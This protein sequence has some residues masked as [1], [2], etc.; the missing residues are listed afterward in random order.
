MSTGAWDEEEGEEKK[1]IL[2]EFL[3]RD[4]NSEK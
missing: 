3:G 1:K 2:L 4:I